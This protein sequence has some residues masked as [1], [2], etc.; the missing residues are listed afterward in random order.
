MFSLLKGGKTDYKPVFKKADLWKDDEN[1]D[2]DFD[3][4]DAFEEIHKAGAEARN[5]EFY[6]NILSNI[7]LL[8]IVVIIYY[9]NDIINYIYNKVYCKKKDDKSK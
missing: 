4:D 2:S 9:R 1:N 6:E 7:F 5:K 8:L 3:Y